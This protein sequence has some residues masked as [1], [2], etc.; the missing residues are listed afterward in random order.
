MAKARRCPDC[1]HKIIAHP[2]TPKRSCLGVDS[3]MEL[4]SAEL[5]SGKTRCPCNRRRVD[6]YKETAHVSV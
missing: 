2:D 3:L 4:T 6:L 5:R 1:N